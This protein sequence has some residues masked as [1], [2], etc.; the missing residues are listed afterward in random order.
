MST[1]HP[2]MKCGHAAQGHDGEGNPVCVI[3]WGI[4]AGAD[5]VDDAPPNLTGR[6]A[7]CAYYGKKANGRNMGCSKCRRGNPCQCTVPS[8]PD[9]AFFEHKPNLAHDKYYCGCWGWD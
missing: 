3:C 4:T 6:I 9:L 7:R 5:V 2:L 8:S 1:R